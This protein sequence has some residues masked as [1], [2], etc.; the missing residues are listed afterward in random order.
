L[1]PWADTIRFLRWTGSFCA[2]IAL[3]GSETRGADL[4]VKAPPAA[5]DYDWT[6]F[7][8]G[9]HIGLATGSSGWSIAPTGGGAPVSGSFGLYQSPNAFKE[10]G[11]WFEGVQGGYNW[12]LRNRVVLGIEGDGSFPTYPDP[13][14]GMRIG[15][16]SNLTSPTFGT[17]SFSENVLASGTFRGRIGYAPG[18]WLFY[19]TGGLAWT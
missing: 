17:G 6:G 15:G 7:Y 19:A 18:H 1:I 9:G 5:T 13:I 16:I 11:S 4:P 8:V 2:V 12:M 14:T 10:S 3:F